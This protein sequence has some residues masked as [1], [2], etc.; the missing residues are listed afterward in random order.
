M[1]EPVVLFIM[2][3][4]LDE[5]RTLPGVLSDLPTNIDGI[6]EIKILVVNDGSQDRTSEVAK[7]LAV[8]YVLHTQ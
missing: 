5:E 3:P 1:S 7:E 4:C 6:D 8:D 2:I